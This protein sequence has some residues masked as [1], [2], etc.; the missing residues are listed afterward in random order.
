VPARTWRSSGGL[1]LTRWKVERSVHWPVNNTR[2]KT[3]VRIAKRD[4]GVHETNVVAS[5]GGVCNQV[6]AGAQLGSACWSAQLTCKPFAYPAFLVT[7][8]PPLQTAQAYSLQRMAPNLAA[9]QRWMIH[10][11]ILSYELT[12]AQMANAAGCSVRAVKYI[13][14][15]LRAF[16]S[17]KAPWNGGGRPQSVTPIMLKALREYLLKNPDRYLDEMAVFLWDKFGALI[18]T[19]TISRTLKA[20][21][22]SKKAC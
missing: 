2:L 11:M 1:Q 18:P 6:P 19:S 12:A 3:G 15:N 8:T 7:L 4:C 10:D 14:S 13:R 16:E 21:G 5:S 20:A 9:S 17:V 22:W